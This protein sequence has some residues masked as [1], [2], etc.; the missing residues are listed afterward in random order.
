MDHAVCPETDYEAETLFSRISHRL[1][2]LYNVMRKDR[3]VIAK[4]KGELQSRG[5]KIFCVYGENL[6]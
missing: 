4:E 6:L 5:R 2:R 1:E 3:E